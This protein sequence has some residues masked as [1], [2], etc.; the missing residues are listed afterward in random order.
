[1]NCLRN[2]RLEGNIE[3]YQAGNRLQREG[4]SWYVRYEPGHLR[5][6]DIVDIARRPGQNNN[7]NVL[8]F[9]RRITAHERCGR[10]GVSSVA[11]SAL[12][13]APLHAD[14]QPRRLNVFSPLTPP[15][16]SYSP[17]L[18]DI[19]PPLLLVLDAELYFTQTELSKDK[20][21]AIVECTFLRLFT[22]G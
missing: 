9:R 18:H 3:R 10:P 20:I 22:H 17:L 5:Q 4:I 7:R 12:V 2:M 13:Q 16:L 8:N 14:V 21:P 1:M 6:L 11:T 15:T 19:A